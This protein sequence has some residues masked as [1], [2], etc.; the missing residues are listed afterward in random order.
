M[1]E[2]AIADHTPADASTREQLAYSVPEAA[3][4]LSM[5]VRKV[6]QL[7]K[8]GKIR[9]YRVG[10]SVR[11]SRQALLDFIEQQENAA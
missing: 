10:R 8:E 11:I 1:H 2:S 7:E 6:W 9:S 4:A 3:K 5:G